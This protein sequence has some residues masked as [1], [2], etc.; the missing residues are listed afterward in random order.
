MRSRHPAALAGWR[1]RIVGP[2]EIVH[3][4]DGSAYL[5][6][7]S[8]LARPLGAQCE[9]AG[10]VFGQDALIAEYQAAS[11]FVYPSLAA[12][13][14]ALPVAPLEAMAAGCATIVS[15]LRCFRDYIEPAVTG[16][17]FDHRGERAADDLAA[18]LAALM[19]DPD[20]LRCLA[21]A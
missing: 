20:R 6:E 11:V 15:D 18:Q 12:T 4:G 8:A 5:D 13:G 2:H 14:E 10:P 1:L 7:L 3:G 9:F 19:A 17:T 21:E 16:L